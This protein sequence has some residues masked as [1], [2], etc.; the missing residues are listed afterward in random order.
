MSIKKG[1]IVRLE[2][3]VVR[4]EDGQIM[5]QIPAMH[6]KP[7]QVFGGTWHDPRAIWFPPEKVTPADS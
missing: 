5:L 2:C 3:E 7:T 1:D 6:M 4:V